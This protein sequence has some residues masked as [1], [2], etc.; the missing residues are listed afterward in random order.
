M[1]EIELTQDKAEE[2]IETIY[3]GGGTPSLLEPSELNSILAKLHQHFHIGHDAEI[4]LEANPD[5][6]HLSKARTWIDEGINR[7]SI[8]IQSFRET[9][10]QWMNRSHT[11]EQAV[12]A[13]SDIQTAGFRNYSIDLI[14]GTPGLDSV[15]WLANLE[16]AVNL[17]IPHLSCYALT[18]EPGTA[19][20]KM[21]ALKKKETTSQDLQAEQFLLMTDNLAMAGYEHYEISNF[22]LPGMHSRH[23]TSYWQGKKYLGFGPSAHSFD[24]HSRSWN[25]SNNVQYIKSL[26]RDIIPSEKE[27]LSPVQQLNEYIMTAI[28]TSAGI[29]LDKMA[30]RWNENYTG[31]LSKLAEPYIQSGKIYRDGNTLMLT[32]E[33]KLFA[34]GIAAAFFQEDDQ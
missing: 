17:H 24:G 19:L 13:I 15:S 30:E 14:F 12:Q 11:A 16:Q 21:I 9:D 4:T 31:I 8:G 10:L 2:T 28:R 33:G 29:N 25:I 5:D 22:S 6:I 3:F 7:L 23:N 26:V 27:I 32:R 20:D 18:V 1:K 34:D